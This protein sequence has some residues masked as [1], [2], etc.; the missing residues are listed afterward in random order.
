MTEAASEMS[1]DDDAQIKLDTDTV[2]VT[3]CT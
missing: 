3:P 1:N 2:L